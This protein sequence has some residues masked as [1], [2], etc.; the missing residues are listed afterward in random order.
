MTIKLPAYLILAFAL[1]L[2]LLAVLLGF[3][4][5]HAVHPA[6]W[7]HAITVDPNVVS[8]SH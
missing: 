6:V 2:L 7:Q 8:H 3:T 5:M 4:V 1:V